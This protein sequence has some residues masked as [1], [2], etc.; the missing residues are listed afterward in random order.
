[1]NP[2][3]ASVLMTTVA[4]PLASHP[5][6]FSL[7]SFFPL[8][9]F[10]LVS[11]VLVPITSFPFPFSFSPSPFFPLTLHPLTPSSSPPCFP[12]SSASSLSQFLL[13]PFLHHFPLPTPLATSFVFLPHSSPA[14]GHLMG[15]VLKTFTKLHV[16]YNII[17]FYL[18]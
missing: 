4:F 16:K 15:G 2:N 12:L 7:S 17:V 8:F 11:P 10:Q 14:P 6:A 3:T 1:M 5:L 13:F 9:R 18:L